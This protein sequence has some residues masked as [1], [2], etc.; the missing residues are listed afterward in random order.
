VDRDHVNGKV[1]YVAKAVSGTVTPI[2]TAIGQA[3]EPITVGF[4]PG[5]IAITP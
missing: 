4:D 1:A 3:R 5:P 2:D